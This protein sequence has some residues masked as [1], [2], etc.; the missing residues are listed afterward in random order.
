MT[1]KFHDLDALSQEYAN[2]NS[3]LSVTDY[4]HHV[5]YT[6]M[7]R[8]DDS[9]LKAAIHEELKAVGFYDTIDSQ[10]W[11]NHVSTP[12]NYA[13]FCYT[14][15][16]SQRDNGEIPPLTF[17]M[18]LCPECGNKRCPKATHHDNPCTHSNDPGQHGSRY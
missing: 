13:C 5:L 6:A 1:S 11:H 8:M 7:L 10:A 15:D 14:C 9:Q 12:T 4:R 16:Q 17:R 2:E 18:N 3:D